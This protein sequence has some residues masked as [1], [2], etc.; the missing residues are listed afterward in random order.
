MPEGFSTAVLLRW[1]DPLG[2]GRFGFNNDYVAFTALGQ[3]V[4]LLTVNFEYII[5]AHLAAT[6]CVP[7]PQ[8]G[9]KIRRSIH[10]AAIC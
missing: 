5:D 3:R 7:R 8:P 6:W 1:G 10:A 9:R 4:A 2:T